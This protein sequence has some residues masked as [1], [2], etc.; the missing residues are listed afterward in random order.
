MTAEEKTSTVKMIYALLDEEIITDREYLAYL[1]EVREFL[2][3]QFSE[4]HDVMFIVGAQAVARFI[5]EIDLAVLRDDSTDAGN[6]NT[7]LS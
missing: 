1:R 5:L 7:S 3:N 2:H 6:L 4:T